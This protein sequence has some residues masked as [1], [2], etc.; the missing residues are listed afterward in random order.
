MS[1][2]LVKEG[3]SSNGKLMHFSVGAIILSNDKILMVDRVKKPFGWACPAGH[4]DNNENEIVS[5]I[6]EVNEETG[7]KVNNFKLLIEFEAFNNSCSKNANIHYWYVY[8][9]ECSGT[10]IHNENE[11]HSIRLIEINEL[12]SLELEPIWKYI[13]N[14]IDL[15]NNFKNFDK[16]I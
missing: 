3:I 5:L 15:K 7:L 10:I 6:R 9:C 1:E 11:T 16:N 4:V 14:K 13:F 8:F 2:I 12:N